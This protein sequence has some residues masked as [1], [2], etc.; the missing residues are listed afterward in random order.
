MA[1]DAYLHVPREATHAFQASQIS[2]QRN[3]VVDK[4]V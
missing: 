1:K 2:L 3:T 4:T